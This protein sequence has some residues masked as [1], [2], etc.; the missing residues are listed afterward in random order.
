MPAP[1]QADIELFARGGLAI[2]R[3]IEACGYNVW[4]ARPALARWEKA[5]LLAGT[6]WKRLRAGWW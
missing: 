1:V 5:G 6:L 2:L 3:K 4:Q